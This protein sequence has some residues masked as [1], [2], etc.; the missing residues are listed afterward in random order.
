MPLKGAGWAPLLGFMPNV[1]PESVRAERPVLN[2]TPSTPL[3]A[4][5]AGILVALLVSGFAGAGAVMLHRS[6]TAQL[7]PNSDPAVRVAEGLAE[8]LRAYTHALEA[9]AAYASGRSKLTRQEWQELAGRLQLDRLPGF[10]GFGVVQVGRVSGGP[11]MSNGLIS[12]DFGDTAASEASSFI[13]VVRFP[14]SRDLA[15]LGAM[16]GM[17]AGDLGAI[18]R[19]ATSGKPAIEVELTS[20][21]EMR[22]DLFRAVHS[23]GDDPFPRSAFVEIDLKDLLKRVTGGLGINFPLRLI[24][25]N[26]GAVIHDGGLGGEVQIRRATLLAADQVWQV[27]VAEMPSNSGWSIPLSYASLGGALGVFLGFLTWRGWRHSEGDSACGPFVRSG[28]PAASE[29]PEQQAFGQWPGPICAVDD[30]GRYLW[31]NHAYGEWVGQLPS[32]LVGRAFQEPGGVADPW[33]PGERNL[34]LPDPVDPKVSRSFRVIR[35][36][37]IHGAGE[38]GL[39][40]VYDDITAVTA[41]TQRLQEI[42]ARWRFALD[43]AGEGLWEWDAR[44]DQF[45]R[46]EECFRIL[47]YSRRAQW[48]ATEE[49][50][51][52]VHPDDRERTRNL[53]AALAAG[54]SQVYSN[55]YRLRDHSGSWRWVSSRGRTMAADEFGRA[56]RVLGVMTDI[57]DRKRAEWAVRETEGRFRR[58]ADSAPVLIWMSSPAGHVSYV[59]KS[60]EEFTGESCASA[61]G[62]GAYLAVHPDDRA[63]VTFLPPYLAQRKAFRAEFRMRRADGVYRW[64]LS[65]GVPRFDGLGTLVGYIGTCTD[66]TDQKQAE[67]DLRSHRDRLSALVAEQTQDLLRAKEVAEAANEAK[68][69]FLANISHELRTPLHA[70]LSNA[71]LGIRK[72]EHLTGEKAR[73]YFDRIQVSGDRLLRLLNDL[74]D[75]SKLEAGRMVLD[76]RPVSLA[77]LVREAVGE[78]E[79]LFVSRHLSLQVH[80]EPDVPMARLD[81]ARAGQVIRNLLANAAKF[82]PEG[83]AIHVRVGGAWLHG[84]P[85]QEA[86]PAASLVVCDGGPGIPD[87]ELDSIFESFVQSSR[88]RSGAGGTGLGL[89][90][91]REIVAA[92]GGRIWAANQKEGGARFEAV[93]PAA[94][95]AR[96][97]RAPHAKGIAHQD[98]QLKEIQA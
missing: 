50:F 90:I 35:H 25:E 98:A 12:P 77:V 71:K 62:D 97:A 82:S 34:V 69:R 43:V 94:T 42:N 78:F 49:W 56:L 92:H 16:D 32:A 33:G 64:I 76:C 11:L 9:G 66:I 70:I 73:E 52:L 22:I 87:D 23:S 96:G 10:V 57:S 39:L 53:L 60:W 7:A 28:I 93:W 41:E 84:D 79:A 5:M 17:D 21:G 4:R 54:Q 86:R 51:A 18:R 38:R 19:A 67:A 40:V 44:T 74:L 15:P 26:G 2:W 3:R 29:G 20:R 1:N 68:S 6:E 91:C 63:R 37:F 31:A 8:E 85:G 72:G 83:G 61:M 58:I 30:G 88:T 48:E 65:H 45:Y 80:E 95:E 13:A 81:P 89:S 47:G 27:E 24:E 36:P 14:P 75:L 59:N 55:E 46:S